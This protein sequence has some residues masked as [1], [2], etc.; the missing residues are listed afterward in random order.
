M[1]KY[2]EILVEV[3]EDSTV[4]DLIRTI[5]NLITNEVG[6]LEADLFQREAIQT[7]SREAFLAYV[8]RTVSTR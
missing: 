3:R 2:P 8:E 4:G 5:H 7:P 6:R 1:P